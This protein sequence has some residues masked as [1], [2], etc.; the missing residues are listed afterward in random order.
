MCVEVEKV[1]R[2]GKPVPKRRGIVWIRN[3]WPLPNTIT[4]IVRAVRVPASAGVGEVNWVEWGHMIDGIA[5]QT[6]LRE[7]DMACE[8]AIVVSA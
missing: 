8:I 5:L 6:K 3:V 4:Q 2:R 7:V 1:L